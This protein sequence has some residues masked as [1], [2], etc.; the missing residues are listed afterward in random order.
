MPSNFQ[1]SKINS[2][3]PLFLAGLFMVCGILVLVYLGRDTARLMN[4]PLGEIDLKP[5]INTQESITLTSLHG[6][7]TVLH[8]WG[9]WCPPCVA[10]YPEFAK[11]Y[12]KFEANPKI[13]IVSVSC[14]PGAENDL[15]QLAIKTKK[16]LDSIQVSMPV[17][18][19]PV[20]YT[21]G[22]VTRMLA[23]G[24]F[25]YPFTLVVDQDGI[26][27]DY[28]LG[29]NKDTLPQVEKLVKKLAESDSAQ[30]Q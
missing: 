17:Y 12:S 29:T 11:I 30:A 26:V 23:A 3:R 10:E 27:R 1:P 13:Q 5:L 25:G 16:Y 24:G 7:V 15:E 28:W 18:C 21:R 20:M 6:K 4:G 19:D 9:T 2:L 22:S 8:F 14:S